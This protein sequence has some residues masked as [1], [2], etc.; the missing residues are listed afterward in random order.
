MEH[1][2]VDWPRVQAVLRLFVLELKYDSTLI[3]II[4]TIT[5]NLWALKI[6][7]CRIVHFLAHL[8]QL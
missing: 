8:L 3:S 4:I 6:S 1:Y 5:T 7:T 2:E